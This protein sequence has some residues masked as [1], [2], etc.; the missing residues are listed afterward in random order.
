MEYMI[1]KWLHVLSSTLLFGMEIAMVVLRSVR[2][3][4]FVR[5]AASAAGAAA[6]RPAGVYGKAHPS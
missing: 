6:V 3:D 2:P 5:P 1:A 4:P